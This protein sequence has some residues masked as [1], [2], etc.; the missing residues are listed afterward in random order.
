MQSVVLP[1]RVC[2]PHGIYL[3]VVQAEEAAGGKDMNDEFEQLIDL[4]EKS[5]AKN[6]EKPLTNKWLLN[7]LK[8]MERQ[9]TPDWMEEQT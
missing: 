6:G 9:Q 3:P 4:L 5:V 2:D 1:Q 7:I 8:M